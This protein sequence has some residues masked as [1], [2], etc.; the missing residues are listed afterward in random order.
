MV[1]KLSYLTASDRETYSLRKL[2]APSF[3]RI[4]KI[5]TFISSTIYDGIKE[6]NSC[7]YNTRW[8]E[9]QELY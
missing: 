2:V 3:G 4:F 7:S 9:A 6:S 8:T 1:K 5:S